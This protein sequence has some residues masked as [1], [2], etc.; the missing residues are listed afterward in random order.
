MLLDRPGVLVVE[1]AEAQ[2]VARELAIGGA[3][4]G[5]R[6]LPLYLLGEY[7]L[8]GEG[9]KKTVSFQL[10]LLRG[11]T[12]LDTRRQA[13][14]A[15]EDLPRLVR[16]GAGEV[17]A[18]ALGQ[19]LKPP[20]PQTEARQLAE[21][22]RLFSRLGDWQEALD[23]TEAALLLQ[24]D[25]Y[26]L[27]GEAVYLLSRVVGD[28]W[29]KEPSVESTVSVRRMARA[30][31]PAN[32]YHAEIYMSHARLDRSGECPLPGL[33]CML[34]F[35]DLQSTRDRESY[36]RN[37]A[38]FEPVRAMCRRVLAAKAAA[39]VD[40]LS[41]IIL[42]RY[43][44]WPIPYTPAAGDFPWRIEFL[45]EHIREIC[46]DR[47][48][49][50]RDFAYLKEG[51]AR[52][53]VPDRDLAKG[54]SQPSLRKKNI[55]WSEVLEIRGDGIRLCS[56]PAYYE[57]LSQSE[58][59]PNPEIRNWAT[60]LMRRWR[61]E[62]T[63]RKQRAEADP[64]K[65]SS[66]AGTAAAGGETPVDDVVFHRIELPIDDRDAGGVRLEGKI[67]LWMPVCRG[68]DLIG[69]SARFSLRKRQPAAGQDAAEL[70]PEVVTTGQGLYLMKKKGE[71][72]PLSLRRSP[73]RMRTG[74]DRGINICS[75]GKYV[76]VASP[77]PARFLAVIDPQSERIWKFTA[78]DGLPPM[79]GQN[80]AAVAPL[81]QGR[82]CV[83]G[84]FG[85]AWCAVA[86]FD[87]QKGK[88]LKV[89]HEARAVAEGRRPGD[90]DPEVASPIERLCTLTAARAAGERP[91]QRVLLVGDRTLLIDP[92]Q[93][94]V[95]G[96]VPGVSA[97]GLFS[98]TRGPCIGRITAAATSLC[99]RP[100][101]PI[102]G[103]RRS[104]RSRPRGNVWSTTAGF[105]CGASAACTRHRVSRKS[106]AC[107]GGNP[108]PPR[109]IPSSPPWSRASTTAWFCSPPT[110][111]IAWSCK[112]REVAA[113]LRDR[114][115][116]VQA[117]GGG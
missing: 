22:A 51:I 72:R 42:C 39:K 10:T 33:P 113:R 91:Q 64:R 88:S 14:A 6:R 23:L 70:R 100:L 8:E 97:G 78:D 36:E 49:L 1:L 5:L 20:D 117:A 99:T 96:S 38:A 111:R 82:V 107:C 50:L 116:M 101:S 30:M 12:Q 94:T 46:E 55:L 35:G 4:A 90:A 69:T 29:R 28:Q 84:Y 32:L 53:H 77:D 48:K 16:A 13:G 3:A 110:G 89:I 81:G 17:L 7:R 56:E 92:D 80:G 86:S 15:V 95:V 24:P 93:G 63:V 105:T 106:S 27:H 65:P 61:E 58:A 2:A 109:R 37:K 87:P 44:E 85:R 47:L 21:R 71:L 76:W 31:L 74:Y 34:A 43:A 66:P 98:R 114:R 18:K 11:T 41:V 103:R 9:G 57:F 79:G 60:I 26:D 108:L 40:D 25:R 62:D 83:A 104:A 54:L 68:I 73:M 45:K 102:S 67:A 59:L 112:S 52:D 19:A 115:L 75:D